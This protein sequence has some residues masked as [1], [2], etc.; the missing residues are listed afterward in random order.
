M[1]EGIYLVLVVFNTTSFEERVL[2]ALVGDLRI[3]LTKGILLSRRIFQR[4]VN[5]WHRLFIEPFDVAFVPLD[6]L[7]LR[8]RVAYIDQLS[9]LKE[10]EDV[11]G[12]YFMVL[13]LNE[14]AS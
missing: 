5:Q 3:D 13:T 7:G 4:V 1:L 10:H 2:A 14:Q 6:L 8:V 11:D 9:P 12:C